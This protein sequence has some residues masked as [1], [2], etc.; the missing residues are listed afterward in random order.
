LRSQSPPR[1]PQNHKI[2]RLFYN[3]SENF[4]GLRTCRFHAF[5][6]NWPR[7]VRILFSHVKKRARIESKAIPKMPQAK[8]PQNLRSCE[9][10]P[11]L[12]SHLNS[13]KYCNIKKNRTSP[14]KY[15]RVLRANIL[16]R[17]LAFLF[18]Q[19]TI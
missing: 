9:P 3:F 18:Y 6:Q 11:A 13:Q 19:N 14:Q 4:E 10:Y 16:Q 8:Q 15:N 2:L 17:M 5:S 7:L 12:G 1:K